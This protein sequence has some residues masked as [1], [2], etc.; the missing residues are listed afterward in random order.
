MFSG[1]HF[2]IIFLSLFVIRH[3]RYVVLKVGGI[4]PL[5][6]ILRDNGAIKPKAEIGGE[7]HKEGS[8]SSVCPATVWIIFTKI[9]TITLASLYN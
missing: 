8:R 4:T 5:G 7:Q 1:K 3:F 2:L 6:A 9:L